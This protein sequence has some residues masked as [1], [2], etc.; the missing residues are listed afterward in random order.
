VK[1]M[2]LTL[3]FVMV[4]LPGIGQ[5]A[6]PQ[7]SFTIEIATNTPTVELGSPVKI[8]IKLTNTSDHDLDMSGSFNDMTG[9]D[10]NFHYVIRDES[11]NAVSRK[12]YN[13]PELATGHPI[14]GRVV[15]PGATLKEEQDVSR[16]HELN[17]PGK[18]LV[19]VVRPISGDVNNGVVK[20]NTITITVVARDTTGGS[21][22][23]Q[24]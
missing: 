16:I 6:S 12:T 20:S 7:P 8:K 2:L 4:G 13:H 5:S 18:Y 17:H 19:Q 15:K 21:R 14:L 23:P 1:N 10:S 3:L 11:D 24:P 9:Q 22:V